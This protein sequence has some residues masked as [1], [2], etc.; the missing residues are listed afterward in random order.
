M[1]PQERSTLRTSRILL[2]RTMTSTTTT[3]T[4]TTIATSSSSGGRTIIA[5]LILVLAVV[6]NASRGRTTF[7]PLLTPT[8]S[9]HATA[10][11]T[12]NP[13]ADVVEN[14]RNYSSNEPESSSSGAK[15]PQGVVGV[16]AHHD[17]RSKQKRRTPCPDDQPYT[18]LEDD[19]DPSLL[20]PSSA[21][22]HNNHN[23]NH[24][25]D[26]NTQK[27]K[28]PYTL[29]QT[30]KGRCLPTDIY[31][32]TIGTWLKESSQHSSLGYQFYDD[33]RM[34]EYL[35]ND[36]Q[37]ASIFPGLSLALQCIEHAQ[38][39]VMKA[40]LWRYL[41]L[42]ER[43]G[44]FAD[45]D[46]VLDTNQSFLQHLRDT[47]DD[48][49]FVLCPHHHGDADADDG[50]G[51]LSQWLMAVC[52]SHPLLYYATERAIELVLKAKRAIP[53]QHTGPRAL[54]DATDRFLM[55]G[56][57]T[58]S[59]RRQLLQGGGTLYTEQRDP[60]K[61]SSSHDDDRRRRSFSF[62]VTP[63]SWAQNLAFPHEKKRLY[64][65]MNMTHY[66]DHQKGKKHYNNGARCLEFLGGVLH[67]DGT[68]YTYSGVTYPFHN[69]MPVV[70]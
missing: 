15:Y 54:N 43:G 11:A 66:R 68:A 34:D 24:N 62:R 20:V 26:H 59:G 12:T 18:W 31:N 27:K 50:G 41:I 16:A 47:D 64:S 70:P 38:L 49:V 44:I 33:P 57:T 46:V 67:E 2:P 60:A 52:P 69:P 25:Y 14:K 22:V 40:D 4:T 39:P 28:I 65:L 56:N 8:S 29:Y 23:H 53:I 42:W 1:G 17:E 9:T 61:A 5:M 7:L 55:M 19:L 30:S 63:A 21:L 37:W 48:A 13:T 45:L 36:T 51:F 10:G 6:N 58:T 3:S 35:R 32:A